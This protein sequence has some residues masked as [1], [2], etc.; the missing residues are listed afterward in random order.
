MHAYDGVVALDRLAPDEVAV[1]AGV[2]RLLEA[3]VLGPQPLQEGL[4][5][6]REPVV[7]CCLGG[8]AGVAASLG[9]LEEGEEGDARGLV[10]V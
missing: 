7:G 9:H 10:L 8:P 4:E 5:G 2:F 1:P 3:A 6:L